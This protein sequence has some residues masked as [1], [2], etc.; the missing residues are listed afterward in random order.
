MIVLSREKDQ[1]V[2]IGNGIIIKILEINGDDVKI[3]IVNLDELPITDGFG[4]SIPTKIN[5]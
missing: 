1:G 3:G 5:E 2:T 4:Q